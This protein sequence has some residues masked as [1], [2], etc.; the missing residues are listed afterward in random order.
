VVLPLGSPQQLQTTERL[1]RGIEHLALSRVPF[2]TTAPLLL[3]I[4][5]FHRRAFRSSSHTKEIVLQLQE[6]YLGAGDVVGMAHCEVKRGALAA[7]RLGRPSI[8]E[9]RFVPAW[10]A[11]CPR[12]SPA[13]PS[14]LSV[15]TNRRRSLPLRNRTLVL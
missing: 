9:A 5:G 6:K 4:A 7:P 10:T 3:E 12:R 15:L 1:E 11:S 2:R 8:G 13:R 14:P